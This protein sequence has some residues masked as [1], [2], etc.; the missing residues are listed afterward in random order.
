[1]TEA[2]SHAEPPSTPRPTRVGWFSTWNSRCG[3]AEYS[4]YLLTEFD[5]NRFDWKVLASHSDVLVAPDDQ[6]VVRC[7]TNSTGTITDLLNVILT[8]RF[9]V[10]VVQ[11]KIQVDFGFL[12]LQQ[13][14]ALIANCHCVGTKIVV[15]LHATD[16]ADPCGKMVPYPRIALALSTVDRVLVHSPQDRDRLRSFGV[17]H[18]VELFPHGYISLA[19]Y[20]QAAVRKAVGFEQDAVLIGSHGFLLPQKGIDVLI[21]AVALLRQTGIPARLLLVTALYPIAESEQH[22]ALCREIATACGIADDVIFETR[23]LP[24]DVSLKLLAA[25]DVIVYPYQTSIESVSGAVRL[26]LA[27]RRLVMCSPLPIFS[28]VAD[29]VH[30]LRGL[31]AEDVCADLQQF[32]ADRAAPA[33]N[34]ERQSEW[35]EQ[36]AWPRLAHLLQDM[37]VAPNRGRDPAATLTWLGQYLTHLEADKTAVVREVEAQQSRFTQAQAQIE[38]LQKSSAHWQNAAVAATMQIEAM[39]GST[40]WRLT[41]PVRVVGEVAHDLRRSSS[42]VSSLLSALQLRMRGKASGETAADHAP[43]HLSAVER[44]IYDDLKYAIDRIKAA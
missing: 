40:S 10:V 16:G 13:L 18:N 3:I 4:K 22:L 28:D 6:R 9:D 38:T 36:H 14:E 37:L 33:A 39:Q 34:I 19:S 1:M 41:R 11:F 24:A 5:S 8:E 26:G 23:F 27:S 20:D 30:S 43:A 2:N 29:V 35:V 32:F 21:K 15:M 31:Q 7:W 12:T 17:E 25:C 42:S 44:A